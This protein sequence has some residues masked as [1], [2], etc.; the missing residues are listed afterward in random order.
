MLETLTS[1]S[2]ALLHAGTTYWIVAQSNE[3]PY[4]NPVWVI[5]GNGSAYTVGNIVF[6]SGPDWQVGQTGGAPGLVINAMP[7][8]EP[9]ILLLGALGAPLLLGAA[10]RRRTVAETA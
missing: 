10:K 8:P 1:A 3:Q 5:G 2:H 7:V 9:S 6:E 4:F